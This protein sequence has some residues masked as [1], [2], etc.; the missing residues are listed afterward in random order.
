MITPSSSSGTPTNLVQHFRSYSARVLHKA[1]VL[2]IAASY[3]RSCSQ[4]LRDGPQSTRVS[5][6]LNTSIYSPSVCSPG[7]GEVV[8]QGIGEPTLRVRCPGGS[9]P[10]PGQSPRASPAPYAYRNCR[11]EYYAV[12]GVDESPSS[13]A[14]T[15]ESEGLGA[16]RTHIYSSPR[17][18]PVASRRS[19]NWQ[20]TRC[21]PHQISK[22][23]ERG[24]TQ[25]NQVTPSPVR[26]RSNGGVAPPRVRRTRNRTLP[27]NRPFGGR[28][29]PASSGA[30][31]CH[32][33]FGSER[34]S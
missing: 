13:S 6:G 27:T 15:S 20:L 17:R 33:L 18:S 19:T 5:L 16:P 23:V 3:V 31:G 7:A 29:R 9:F 4:G 34:Q 8:R 1:R 24:P 22:P 32:L 28:G 21:L 11:R 2:T 12:Y 30:E 26:D 14:Q 25:N 10:P